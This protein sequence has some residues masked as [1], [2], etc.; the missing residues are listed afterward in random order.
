MRIYI[1]IHTHIFG[2][3]CRVSIMNGMGPCYWGAVKEL[4]L[5]Y[6]TMEMYRYIHI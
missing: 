2:V 1:Y 4:T 6:R 3:L 5:D